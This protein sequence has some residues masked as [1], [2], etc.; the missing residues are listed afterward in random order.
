M[1]FLCLAAL[2]FGVLAGPYAQADTLG[3]SWDNDVFLGQD[4]N[5][6]NGVRFS[7]VDEGHTQCESE[8]GLTC[9]T[10]RL[11]D[12][13]P[14][15]SA[16]SERH[17]FTVSLEQIMITPNDIKRETPD[18]N[19]LPYVGYTNLEL[20]LFS[21]DADSLYGYGVRIGIVGPD[22][23]A[24]ESQK[25]VHRITG[26]NEPEGWDNQLGQD[27]IG[28]AYFI[29]AHRL[30]RHT[31]DGGYQTELGYAWG[32]D[33]NNFDGNA[34]AGGFVRFGRNLPGNFIPDY[35]GIGTAGS[36][37]GL[38]DNPGFGWEVFVGL[39]GQYV[40][41]SYIERKGDDYDVQARDYIGTAVA[42]F[43]LHTDGFSFTMTVQNSTSPIRDSDPLSFG[44]MSFMW[45]L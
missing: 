21:W 22:S 26:S 32:V 19:D 23:G 45:A 41:Y 16:A 13:L 27:L 4:K 37:V 38:F 34:Q 30:F 15:I 18:Y 31:S 39:S 5:Y 33:A 1:R 20:G 44:N 40:G 24:E 36:L 35:A 10:A 11:L 14:G 9:G 2:M 29:N 8:S 25:I 42:G 3:F 17:A 43:G 7:W 28:G 12:P 6:T